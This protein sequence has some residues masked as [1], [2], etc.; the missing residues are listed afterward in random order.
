M[1]ALLA[2]P[3][4]LATLEHKSPLFGTPLSAAIA[5]SRMGNAAL[6]DAVS[7]LL[8]AGAN[9]FDPSVSNVAPDR[10]FNDG[11]HQQSQCGGWVRVG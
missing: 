7:A 11:E 9:I 8:V 2:M 10:L 3:G 6:P 5:A 1:T 4:A